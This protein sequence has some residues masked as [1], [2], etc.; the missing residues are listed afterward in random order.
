[1]ETTTAATYCCRETTDQ[2]EWMNFQTC[3][4]NA[5]FPPSHF[6]Q[7]NWI[8]Q[9]EGKQDFTWMWWTPLHLEN[10]M[11]TFLKMLRKKYHSLESQRTSDSGATL[12]RCGF[13]EFWQE[14]W[15]KCTDENDE[16]PIF[17]FSEAPGIALF[18][19]AWIASLR[20]FEMKGLETSKFNLD[21]GPPN[22]VA[23]QAGHTIS[24]K[25]NFGPHK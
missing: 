5:P 25:D 15:L 7:T 10:I 17:I 6:S 11:K 20:K 8:K 13:E 2:P 9:V 1:M 12:L 21:N 18:L 23:M 16:Y 19:D 4:P 22:D 3:S 24:V 14:F